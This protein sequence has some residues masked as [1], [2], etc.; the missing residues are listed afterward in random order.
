MPGPLH[1][2]AAPTETVP[3]VADPGPAD[4]Y[5]TPIGEDQRDMAAHPARDIRLLEQVL[6]VSVVETT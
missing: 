1:P 2:Q 4:R 5:Q 3:T 6:E